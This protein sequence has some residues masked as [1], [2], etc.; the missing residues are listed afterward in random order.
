MFGLVFV[1]F[2]IT[3]M[4]SYIYTYKYVNDKIYKYYY[5]LLLMGFVIYSG[6]GI[7]SEYSKIEQNA[8]LYMIQWILFLIAFYLASTFVIKF[9]LKNNFFEI[10]KIA[11]HKI[12]CI[13]GTVYILT[14]FYMCISSKVTI[15]DLFNIKKLFLEYKATPFAIRVERRNNLFYMIMTNQVATVAEPF[16]Y[17]WLYNLRK[18]HK[19]FILL[20]LTPILLQ[21]LADRYLSRNNIA[22][23]LFF[24]FIFMIK[25][26]I[27]SKQI[28]KL[29]VIFVIPL[30]L[31]IFSILSDIRLKT[32]IEFNVIYNIKQ[33]IL[34]EI[35]Y[36]EYY[37]YCVIKSKEIS[38]LNFIIYIF[39]VCIPSQI[40]KIFNFTVPNLAYSFTEAILGL[41][42]GETNNY[43]ILLPSVLGEALMLFGKNFAFMYGFIYGTIATFFLKVLKKNKCLEYL[44]IFF[45]LDFFRQFR[46]GSQYVIS[47]W[48]AK[49]IPMLIIAFLVKSSNR[50][51]TT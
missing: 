3:I 32:T 20:Y 36:P 25:E 24:L 28:A 19:I 5:F 11:S 41:N 48:E 33:L 17:I 26:K 49:L 34:D 35:S 2:L 29:L 40:Y 37:N 13:L 44:L 50:K 14:Y 1:L 16:Y 30:L 46:G 51:N 9:K 42:Y 12:I 18:K 23:Y 7:I 15:Q 27:I 45:L 31:V 38:I 6:A 8:L 47:T 4:L 22:V 39:I 43:Y 10:D 21:L